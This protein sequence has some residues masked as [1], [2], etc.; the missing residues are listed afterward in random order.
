MFSWTG[1]IALISQLIIVSGAT[2]NI[3]AKSFINKPLSIL[4]FL[5]FSPN[6]L[7]FDGY[8]LSKVPIGI[9]LVKT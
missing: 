9:S 7:G 4:N 3:S 2:F 8:D 5:I 1:I 6:V